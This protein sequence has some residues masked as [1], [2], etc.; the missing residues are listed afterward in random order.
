ME[1]G[2]LVEQEVIQGMGAIPNIDE[3]GTAFRVWAPHAEAVWVIGDFNDWND[4]SNELKQEENG[5]WMVFIE[6]AKV[7]Q[8]YK[9][10]ISNQGEKFQR[11]DPYAR[12]MTNSN[13]NSVICALYFEWKCQD[14][15]M[16]DWNR[17]VIYELHIGTFFRGTD[18]ET[19]GTF[20]DAIKR[21][22]Y[23]KALGINCIEIM[24]IT[25]F[26]G[27][28]SWGYNPSAPFAVER[29]YGGPIA[30]AKFIDEAHLLG[31]AVINDV[32]YNHFG[33]SDMDLWQFD[34]WSE[35]DKGGIYFYNDYRSD[36]P[37]GQT[38]PDYGRPEVRQYIMDNAMMWLDAYKCDGLRWDATAYIRDRD[39]GIGYVKEVNP[40]GTYMMK[41]INSEV[42]ARIPGKI[43]IAEDL[44]GEQEV[45][46]KYGDNALHFDSQWDGDFVHP[47][48]RVLTA[49]NDADR[50]LDEITGALFNKYN[51]DAF[52]RV[53]FTE[54]HDE[55][56][57]GKSRIPDEIQPGKADSEYA[58]KRSI[59]G[60]VLVFTGPG[61]PMIFQGQEFL[62]SSYFKDDEELDWSKFSNFKG[63]TKLYRDLIKFRSQPEEF[64][65]YGL[66]GNDIDIVHFNNNTKVLAFNRYHRDHL[67]S[68]TLV[69]L[70]FSSTIYKE[71]KIGIQKTEGLRTLFNST[72]DGYDADDFQTVPTELSIEQNSPYDSAEHTLSFSID[73]YAAL[74]IV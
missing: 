74:I 20:E 49:A 67:D 62:E 68:P 23:L 40:E 6:N 56:A 5:N 35:N 58:K 32:V 45:T 21:L 27:G 33:P 12:E 50:N 8:E 24:P 30:L 17:L 4:T 38:R 71:Y 18:K 25:E 66:I 15:V 14:F 63:I 51:D 3:S 59:L 53:I 73:G 61:I 57:N 60:A 52:Q 64:G 48:K 37:W 46:S 43:M 29:D 47:V 36:T 19:V 70:N 44:K 31:M 28:I 16:P 10:V 13:G 41:Q 34:G 72:W 39:G 42:H 55:V 65:T 54:S 69:I 2:E 26:A 9:F 11:N 1:T 22:P 7:G